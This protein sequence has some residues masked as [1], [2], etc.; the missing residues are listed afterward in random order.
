MAGGRPGFPA[1]RAGGSHRPGKRWKE[2]KE[3]AGEAAPPWQRV[4][5]LALAPAGEAGGERGGQGWRDG[6]GRASAAAC[7]PLP[8][9]ERGAPA[10]AV[11]QGRARSAPPTPRAPLGRRQGE[12][13]G[14]PPPQGAL[15]RGRAGRPHPPC[16]GRLTLPP[17]RG[18]L[19]FPAAAASA[20]G[21]A[22]PAEQRSL[23]HLCSVTSSERRAG[24]PHSPSRAGSEVTVDP[25]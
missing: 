3:R 2:G 25:L 22:R 8:P 19:T 11:G 12:P 21:C 14:P 24:E 13:P 6:D 7:E 15:G 20:P 9:A 18:G 23:S 4:P 10:A 17:C 1:G 5:G 16:P